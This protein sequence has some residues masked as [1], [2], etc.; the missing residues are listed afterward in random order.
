MKLS[1]PACLVL[2]LGLAPFSGYMKENTVPPPDADEVVFRP[3][4][5]EYPREPQIVQGKRSAPEFDFVALKVE[6]VA[7][8]AQVYADFSKKEVRVPRNL[9]G[10]SMGFAGLGKGVHGYVISNFDWLL[11]NAGVDIVPLGRDVVAFRAGK[12]AQERQEAQRPVIATPEQIAAATAAMSL[13]RFWQIMEA[14][15]RGD[16]NDSFR[17]AAVLQ[18]ALGKLR[19]EEILGFQLRLNER[20]AESYRWDLWAVAYIVNGGASDDGFEYFRAWL[21]AQ[22]RE[23]YQA[24]L[25]D[26]VRAADRA[27]MDQQNESEQLLYAAMEAYQAKTNRSAPQLPFPGT[28]QPAGRAWQEEE[29]LKLYPELVKRFH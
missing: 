26:P 15:S 29:L 8:V 9:L 17:T 7:D 23:Y 13:D 5:K 22:G 19:V 28:G 16:Q 1:L 27:G 20:M 25:K 24:A 4:N 11:P 10:R 12:T 14:T 21:I 18:S 6:N 2:L 3:T